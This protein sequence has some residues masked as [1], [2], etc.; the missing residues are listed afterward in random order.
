MTSTQKIKHHFSLH[1]AIYTIA[2]LQATHSIH[3]KF[4]EF[5]VAESFTQNDTTNRQLMGG[6]F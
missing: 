4:I 3:T 5:K 1:F 6:T 2:K